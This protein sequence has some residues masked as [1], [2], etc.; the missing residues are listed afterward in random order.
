[1]IMGAANT[2]LDLQSLFDD[3]TAIDRLPIKFPVRFSHGR[4]TVDPVNPVTFL[5]EMRDADLN[6][7]SPIKLEYTDNVSSDPPAWWL[8]KRKKTRNWTGGVQVNSLRVDMV[9]LLTP[10]SGPTHIKKHEPTFADIH[11][12]VMSVEAP[13][14]PFPIDAALADQG[15]ALFNQHCAPSHGT[16]GPARKYPDKIVPLAT[17]GTDRAL[18][19]SLTQTNL[20]FFNQTWFAQEKGPDGTWYQV[21]GTPGY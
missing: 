21:E 11:A 1:M 14:Y 2:S 7:R 20:A 15:R 10:L 17:I 13:K 16:Y 8:L 19:E 3:L 5:A 4:G 6:L 18:A 9:N 12:F